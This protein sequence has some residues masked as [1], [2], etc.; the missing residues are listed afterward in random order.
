MRILK[1][2]V[3]SGAVAAVATVMAV[4]PASAEPINPHTGKLVTPS[5][6]DIV[7]VGSESTTFVV[8][9][10]TYAYDKAIK[11]NTPAT[12]YIYSWD[13]VPPNNMN[14]TTQQIVVKQGCKK[15]ARPNGSSAG[16][17]ALVGGYGN[18]SY[19]YKGKKHTVPC[20]DFARSSRPRKS[21][22]PA[23]AKGGVAFVTMA[24]DAVTYASTNLK[25]E[26]TNVPQNLNQAQLKEIFGC[27]VPAKGGFKANTW[28]ALLGSK[29]KGATQAIDP[30]LPQAG[31]GTLSFWAI[32]A[33]G[34]TVDT[35]PTCGTA[36]SLTVPNQPEENEG[37]SKVFLKGGKPNPNVIYPFSIASFVAQGYHSAKCGHKP[38]KTQNIF[39]CDI[40]GIFGL[41]GISRIAP[42]VKGPGGLPVTNPK[43]N[44]TP[45]HRFL[46]NV[47]PYAT[48]TKDHIPAYLEKFFGRTGY[49]CKSTTILKNYGD[50]PTAACGLTS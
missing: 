7:G 32:T 41:N 35:E 11:T 17:S 16:V 14:N 8:G 45:F 28:G 38:T 50:E 12:P 39:G 13:A 18:T 30:I 47:V 23:F 26:S 29:A 21:T 4:A 43:W 9:G 33:L 20:I 25:G 6:W 42:T 36:K 27:T 10:I 15:N 5:A 34:L 49:F 44:S 37:T 19:S 31:S 40:N 48:N 1:T 3:A 46:F 22:D 24:G 2:L